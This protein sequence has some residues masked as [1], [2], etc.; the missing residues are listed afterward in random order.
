GDEKQHESYTRELLVISAGGGGRAR[1]A[2]RRIARWEGLRVWRR[3][4]QG[5]AGV[6]YAACMLLLYATL[7]PFALLVRFVR[8][9]QSGWRR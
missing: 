2:L 9:A 6:V 1:R 8:P 3:S 7:L 4:G 5:L